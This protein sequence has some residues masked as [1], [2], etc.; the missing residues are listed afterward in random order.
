M[1]WHFPSK[2]F[3]LSSSSFDFFFFLPLWIHDFTPFFKIHFY[4]YSFG[5]MLKFSQIPQAGVLSSWVL[6]PCDMS[7]WVFEQVVVFWYK[8]FASTN[9]KLCHFVVIPLRYI[10]I[11]KSSCPLCFKIL[12]TYWRDQWSHHKVLP[13]RFLWLFPHAI[14]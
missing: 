8:M 7:L 6:C 5:W 10:L 9:D 1:S 11:Q 12:L 3:P 14:I 2:E 13:S 4:H